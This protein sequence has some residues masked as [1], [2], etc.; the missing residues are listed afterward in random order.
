M[1][2]KPTDALKGA[3]QPARPLVRLDQDE[4]RALEKR[5]MQALP[6]HQTTPLQGGVAIGVEYVLRCVREGWVIGL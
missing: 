6:N 1:G 3:P 4:Y 5:V 2:T